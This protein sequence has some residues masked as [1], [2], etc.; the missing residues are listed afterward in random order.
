MEGL[1]Q[2]ANIAG[3]SGLYRILKPSRAGVI[4][5]S[6]DNKKEKTMMVQKLYR[7]GK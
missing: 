5:E 7:H 1:R 3:Y 4:V 2:I 6:L